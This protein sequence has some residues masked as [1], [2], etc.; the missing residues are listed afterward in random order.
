MPNLC[1]ITPLDNFKD[2][3]SKKNTPKNKST[4]V[5]VN[6]EEEAESVNHNNINDPLSTDDV[7]WGQ[8]P[9]NSLFL[10]KA[11]IIR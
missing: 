10:I 5:D 7:P 2:T 8:D 11:G 1:I 4:N 3:S 6:H 9:I